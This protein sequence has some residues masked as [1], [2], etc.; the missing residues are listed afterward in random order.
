LAFLAEKLHR[1]GFIMDLQA[2]IDE[3][4]AKLPPELKAV[5]DAALAAGNKLIDVEVGRGG[6][7]VA[8][9][10]DHPFKIA[11]D[12]APAGVKYLEFLNRN[13]K[14]FGF[15]T[16]DEKHSLVTAVFK[17]MVLE[18]LPPGP[19]NPTEA[20]IAFMNERAKKD[21]EAAAKRKAIIKEPAPVPT[22]PDTRGAASRFISSMTMT[23]DMWHDGI[24]Y[25]TALLRELSP[26]ELKDIE[27]VLINHSPRDWRNIEALAQIDSEPA[28]KAVEAALKS[29]DPQVRREAMKYAGEKALP[30]DREKLLLRGLESDDLFGG[31]SQAIDEAAEFHPPAVV[32]AL[33][34][35]A[36]N[37]SAPAVVHFVALLFYIHGKSKEPFDWD[38][39]PF[40]LSFDT[41]NREERKERFRELC[42]MIG[43]D[44]TKYLRS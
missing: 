32:E 6:G 35:G 27:T 8:L 40:F 38:H 30:E 23:F 12:A 37:R 15:Y 25:D 20:H 28:R 9:V 13:P 36:L 11:A 31:L 26:A 24:G 18:P 42:E 41:S 43:V 14:L 16:A 39:R 3:Q 17:P 2:R 19:P 5:L 7:P 10:M 1:F 29:A 44:V 33:M 34:R 4:V 22:A 21:E